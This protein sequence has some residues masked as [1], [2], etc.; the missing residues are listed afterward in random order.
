MTGDRDDGHGGGE[1]DQNDDD[2]GRPPDRGDPPA[3]DVFERRFDGAEELPVTIVRSVAAV[4][5]VEPATLPPLAVAVDTDALS[6][7]LDEDRGAVDRGRVRV[8][9][10]YAGCLVVVDGR[11]E[12]SVRYPAPESG[13][14]D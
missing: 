14:S 1:D 10:E 3:A 9:F 2:G 5:G 4:R 12:I 7:L 13:E 8:S 11:G 6:A